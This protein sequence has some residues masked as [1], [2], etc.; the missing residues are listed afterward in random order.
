MGR[1][2]AYAPGTPSWVDLAV[3]DLEGARAFYADLF[4]W[5]ADV[6]EDPSV[7]GYTT[8]RQDGLAV[9]GVGGKMGGPM[10]DAWSV[11]MSVED[12]E[13][14]LAVVADSGG[15]VVAG[16]MPILE[17]GV[18]GMFADPV[19]T[20]AGVWQPRNHTGAELVNVPNT[21]CWS[22]L[23]TPDLSTSVAFYS[24][25]FGWQ[26]GESAGGGTTFLD[27]DGRAI[28]GAHDAGEGEFPAWS[29]WFAVED[30]DGTVEGVT[31][32]GGQ[33]FMAPTD[34]GFGRG[35]VVAAPGGAVF[36]VATVSEP[37]D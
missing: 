6:S 1:R 12:A 29:V 5:T 36:G 13:R 37:D 11:H 4:G 14:T 30:C 21:F 23:A 24:T 16:P 8:F 35:A 28:C 34:M 18:L 10:P 27:A 22:E 2:D 20:F 31:A 25:V 15:K 7:G 26:A 17:E 9:A 3:D 33:V 32:K 19:G